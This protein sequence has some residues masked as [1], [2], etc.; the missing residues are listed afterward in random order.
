MKTFVM[1]MAVLSL[2]LTIQNAWAG[3]W[4]RNNSDT[5]SFRGK[6]DDGEYDKFLKVFD[7]DVKNM[8]VTSG[9]GNVFEAIKI[10]EVLEKSDITIRVRIWCLSSCANYFFTAAK[11]KII[12]KGI[13][14]YHGNSHACFAK[15]YVSDDAIQKLREKYKG[16][17]MNAEQIEMAISM[18]TEMDRR[19]QGLLKRLG[20]SQDLFV[21]TCTADKGMNDG[22]G[23]D[24]LLP[25]PATFEKYGIKNVVG[26]QDQE[27]IEWYSMGEL[28]VD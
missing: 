16:Y 26:I 25:T 23:Y 17:G 20:V 3:T 24:F 9:G 10:A 19:E 2:N 22:K 7:A 5:I 4:Q 6:I 15:N 13:V 18:A 11:T 1:F 12:E 14:G 8:I 28:V 27:T 21:R